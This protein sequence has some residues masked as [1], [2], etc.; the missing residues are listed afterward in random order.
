MGGQRA[1]E[2][3]SGCLCHLRNGMDLHRSDI[4]R[5]VAA[6]SGHGRHDETDHRPAERVVEKL[7][8]LRIAGQR[9]LS[10][11][12]TVDQVNLQR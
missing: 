7:G 3:V 9:R 11:L 10:G 12:F 1:F 6:I 8:H 4:Q 5:F 2:Q